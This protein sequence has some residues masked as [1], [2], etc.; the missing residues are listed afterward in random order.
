[1]A[2]P[3]PMEIRAC[4][5]EAH[6]N[7]ATQLE[8]ADQFEIAQST[9]SKLIKKFSEDQH[10]LPRKAKGAEPLLTRDEYSVVK[11]IVDNQPDITLVGIKEQIQSKLGKSPGITTVWR[12]VKALNLKRKRKSRFASERDRND[13]KKKR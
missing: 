8:I 11:D 4:I 2:S 7:G 5:L 13:V 3:I 9:V 6:S 12:I 10:L 1:M